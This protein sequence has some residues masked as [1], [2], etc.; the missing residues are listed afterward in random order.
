M[1]PGKRRLQTNQPP[2]GATEYAEA[3][4]HSFRPF[5]GWFELIENPGLSPG[6]IFSRAYGASAV[7]TLFILFSAPA[8]SLA[9][10]AT[11]STTSPRPDRQHRAPTCCSCSSV[12]LGRR[13]Q[14]GGRRKQVLFCW[15][16]HC[17]A[18]AKPYGHLIRAV[19]TARFAHLIYKGS[20]APLACAIRIAARR[21]GY[22][23]D[24]H[25]VTLN[26][27]IG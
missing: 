24:A 23:R 25:A 18:A 21:I 8:A 3:R 5:R 4:R 11:R 6:A 20:R 9:S 16:S 15:L 7:T 13:P 26:V 12:L 17:L 2:A 22:C 27:D 19:S 14:S 10:G 1:S